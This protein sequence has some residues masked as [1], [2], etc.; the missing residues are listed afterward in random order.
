[1]DAHE[2]VVHEVD[3]DGMGVVRGPILARA[4]HA[5]GRI[6]RAIRRRQHLREGKLYLEARPM[7]S[8][9]ARFDEL[10]TPI[11]IA[12]AIL[13]FLYWWP[14]GLAVLAYTV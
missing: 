9:A 2:I 12:L 8:F 13:G 10:K 4:R 1:M 3:R 7:T 6:V 14:L 11:W 5:A